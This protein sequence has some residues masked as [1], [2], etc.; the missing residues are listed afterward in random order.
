MNTYIVN[1]KA[2]QIFNTLVG[3]LSGVEA[4]IRMTAGA[5]QN[6]GVEL[7]D[8]DLQLFEQ[9]LDACWMNLKNVTDNV[10]ANYKECIT[11]KTGLSG[12]YALNNNYEVVNVTE[13]ERVAGHRALTKKQL[14]DEVNHTLDFAIPLSEHNKEKLLMIKRN[15]ISQIIEQNGV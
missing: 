6:Y 12:L 13:A 11:V 3:A 4:Q 7:T 9:D 2:E 14:L 8:E 5:F 15:L 10:K 1:Q